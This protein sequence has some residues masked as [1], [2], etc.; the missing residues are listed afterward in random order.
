M[1]TRR[2]SFTPARRVDVHAW[3]RH[4]GAVALDP[5][6]GYYAFAY[7]P[8]WIATG[9]ELAPRQMPL[10]S[11]VQ[12]FTDL[13]VATYKRLPALLADALPD[14]FGNALVNSFMASK[15]YSA[16]QVTALDRLAYMG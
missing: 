11:A 4:V 6:L 13:P 10:S 14:D 9:I 5:R 12:V 1:A 15:G 8:E 16:D 7:T 3:G 2:T